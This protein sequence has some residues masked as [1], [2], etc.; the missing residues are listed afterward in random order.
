MTRIMLDQPRI[1]TCAFHS[2]KVAKAQDIH[3]D[4]CQFNWFIVKNMIVL[5]MRFIERNKS[6]A[7]LDASVK[8]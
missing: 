2:T 8:R 5:P 7:G 6:K 3:R 1:L 4:D